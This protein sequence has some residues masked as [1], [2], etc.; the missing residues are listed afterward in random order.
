MK[1]ILPSDIDIYKK[2]IS[3]LSIRLSFSTTI[4]MFCVLQHPEGMRNANE[5]IA[6]SH[7]YSTHLL[8][9]NQIRDFQSEISFYLTEIL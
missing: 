8:N 4:Y 3:N 5:T 7:K 6:Q 2:Y 9:E 1:Y